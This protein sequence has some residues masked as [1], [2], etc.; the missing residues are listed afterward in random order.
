[1][2]IKSKPQVAKD[3][4]LHQAEQVGGSAAHPTT[5][6]DFL[7]ACTLNLD[8]SV[9]S[10]E[11][12]EGSATCATQLVASHTGVARS[13]LPLLFSTTYTLFTFDI[14][15]T[16][17]SS[18]RDRILQIAFHNCRTGASIV[19]NLNIYPNK[20]SKYAQAVH[21]ITTEE[22]CKRDKP[23]FK[24]IAEQIVR[25]VEDCPGTPVLTGHNANR[26]D[27]RML[28]AEFQR[29]GLQ[30]LLLEHVLTWRYLDTLLLVQKVV[31]SGED[32]PQKPRRGRP[33]TK[34]TQQ[35]NG[36]AAPNQPLPGRGA[37][38][39]TTTAAKFPPHGQLQASEAPVSSGLP[40][41]AKLK[42]QLR[43]GQLAQVFR[44]DERGR[45]H[46]AYSDALTC[47]GILP[48]IMALGDFRDVDALLSQNG[49]FTGNMLDLHRKMK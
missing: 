17:L 15:S 35:G 32:L 16:G 47:C 18:G 28:L 22:A 45:A 14:E 12:V 29:A 33:S 9:Q 24:D 49:G 21:G 44:V 27:C 46:D 30:H 36:H 43:L 3:S 8:N 26:F 20:V 11:N 5:E 37:G 42:G 31:H 10:Q 7:E 1:M 25:F 40:A 19:F 41:V 6:K 4:L 38:T 23:F 48:H 39:G 2:P 34:K 13:S